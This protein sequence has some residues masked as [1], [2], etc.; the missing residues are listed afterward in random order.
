MDLSLRRD[1]T[2]RDFLRHERAVKASM[3]SMVTRLLDASQADVYRG[4]AVFEDEHTIRIQPVHTFK[5]ATGPQA[6]TVD[7]I[8]GTQIL[9]ATG[10]SPARPSIFQFEQPRNV[11]LRYDSESELP[12]ENAGGGRCRDRGM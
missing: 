1:A 7:L 4:V 10:S 2:V 6:G 9:V 8:R 11:R 5:D 12:T 3:N